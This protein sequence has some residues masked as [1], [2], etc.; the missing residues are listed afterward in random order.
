MELKG[1]SHAQAAARVHAQIE[2]MLRRRAEQSAEASSPAPAALDVAEEASSPAALDA[3]A[4]SP[5]VAEAA[6][7]PAVAAPRDSAG[8]LIDEQDAAYAASLAA[9]AAS[10]AGGPASTAS[11]PPLTATAVV[12]ATNAALVDDADIHAK[13]VDGSLTLRMLMTAVAEALGFEGDPKALK[14]IVKK[15][16]MDYLA[17]APATPAATGPR[18][19]APAMSVNVKSGDEGRTTVRVALTATVADLRSAL[20]VDA[21]PRFIFMGRILSDDAKTLTSY[22]VK[23]GFTLL[24]PDYTFQTPR[25]A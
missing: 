14:S 10:A 13:L 11:A 21:S 4:P 5:A 2:A 20:G 16:L 15:A 19:A 9:D 17:D 18:A 1:L 23:D 7:S 8:A 24:S 22:G 25:G 12:E 6:P 3:A